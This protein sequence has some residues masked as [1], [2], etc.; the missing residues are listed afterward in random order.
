MRARWRGI[1]AVLGLVYLLSGLFF[2]RADQQALV[3]RLGKVFERPYEPGLHWTWPRPIAKV[4]KLRVRET[5][6]LAVGYL[7]P[8]RVLERDSQAGQARFLTGDRNLLEI[9]VIVQG[10]MQAKELMMEPM[11]PPPPPGD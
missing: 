2:V 6:R 1:A 3:F 11:S 5:K 4:I 8:E 9:R 7:M 10:I